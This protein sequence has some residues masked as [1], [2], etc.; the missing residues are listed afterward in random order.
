MT[1]AELKAPERV[2]DFSKAATSVQPDAIHIVGFEFDGTACFRKGTRM[3]P[4][5]IRVASY[6]IETYSPTLDR[7]TT[8][9]TSFYDLGNLPVDV[10]ENVEESWK[11]ATDFYLSLTKTAA[12]NNSRFILL[13]GEHSV[14][15]APIKSCLDQYPHLVVVQLDAHA[16]LRDGYEGY[17]YSHASVI[18]RVLDHFTESN[19]LVQ[20]GIRS[21][22]REEFM[23][24]REYGTLLES[25]ESLLET[26]EALP[27][28][29]P[30]YLTL[31]LD[32]F[33]PSVLPGT[34]TPEAGGA[35]YKTWLRVMNA[36]KNKNVVGADIVE[37][38]PNLDATGNSNVL[39]GLALRELILMMSAK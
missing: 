9:V 32:F 5:A 15:W 3:G 6:D 22:T 31:D 7:D 18:R 27:A 13:G 14:S 2:F 38:A 19:R 12:E 1:G 37:L 16:D 33:D 10:C 23:W 20:H 17:H 24:M 25:E 35:E 34:G 28:E 11:N 29:R 36:L 30:V 21:G 4:D 39:A 8:M 26:L